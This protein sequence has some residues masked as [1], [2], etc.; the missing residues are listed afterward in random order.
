MANTYI[1]SI[2]KRKTSSA[3]VRVVEG[4]GE[5]TINGV[6]ASEY[7]KRTDL[8]D[9]V[10]TPLKLC[11]LKDTMYF[12]AEVMGS[13]PSAQAQAIRH[14]LSR[15]IAGKDEGFKAILKQAGL[16]TRDAR[17]VERKKP[18]KHKARK[19]MQWSKR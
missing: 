14:G 2:G 8:F 18:G 7:I 11:K 5:S 15:A 17:K 19:S 6:K 13:G 4:K 1:Y 3:Q 12:E 9:V 10:F 16:L